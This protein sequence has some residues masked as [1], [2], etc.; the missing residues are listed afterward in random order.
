MRSSGLKLPSYN[1]RQDTTALRSVEKKVK[2]VKLGLTFRFPSFGTQLLDSQVTAASEEYRLAIS[3]S[4]SFSLWLPSPLDHDDSIGFPSDFDVDNASPAGDAE[5]GDGY[6]TFSQ[7]ERFDEDRA[8]SEAA[9]YMPNSSGAARSSSN[10][11]AC[12]NVRYPSP[13]S[14]SPAGEAASTAKSLWNPIKSS[15]SRGILAPFARYS[16]FENWRDL[17]FNIKLGFGDIM[18]YVDTM[19]PSVKTTH[20]CVALAIH[21]HLKFSNEYVAGE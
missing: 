10:R 15:P 12:E 7:A 14:A 16:R 5:G 2:K 9:R 8:S 4:H 19:L 21:L 17:E 13:P 3:S 6:R 11:S 1:S 18:G 20:C